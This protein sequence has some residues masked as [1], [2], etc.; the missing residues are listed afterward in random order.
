MKWM[1]GRTKKQCDRALRRG[2]QA[3]EEEAARLLT[4]VAEARWRAER[5]AAE[6]KVSPPP[7]PSGS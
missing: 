6:A 2:A 7:P 3:R 5:E 1:N 4:E